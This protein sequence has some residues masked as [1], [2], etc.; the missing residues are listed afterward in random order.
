MPMLN[1]AI[2]VFSQYTTA[3]RIRDLKSLDRTNL[4]MIGASREVG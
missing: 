2:V 3:E 4:E 1:Q